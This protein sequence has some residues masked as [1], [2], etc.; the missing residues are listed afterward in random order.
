[1]S[2]FGQRMAEQAGLQTWYVPHAVDTKVFK[3]HDQAEARKRLGLPADKFIVGMVAANKGI[4]PRKAFFEQITAFAALHKQHPDTLLY[5]HTDDGTHGGEVVN[6]VR[7]CQRVGLNLSR[8]IQA[9]RLGT[10]ELA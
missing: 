10:A 2:K 9:A 5:M 7:Y 8:Q 3:P 6:L 4:P 1:M